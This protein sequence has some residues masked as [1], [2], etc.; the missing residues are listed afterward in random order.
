MIPRE[1]TFHKSAAL[2]QNNRFRQ[3]F[4]S[5]GVVPV[6]SFPVTFSVSAWWGYRWPSVSCR[7]NRT[8]FGIKHQQMPVPAL[9]VPATK[10]R[11]LDEWFLRFR[12]SVRILLSCPLR[13]LP[14]RPGLAPRRTT[15]PVRPF[16]GGMHRCSTDRWLGILAGLYL[17]ILGGPPDGTLA[18]RIDLL[19]SASWRKPWLA[20]H[21]ALDHR[22]PPFGPRLPWHTRPG[23]AR[24]PSGA[25]RPGS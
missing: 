25:R 5:F 11:V 20:I 12:A 3:Y 6:I 16:S 14:A 22:A 19:L 1:A 8:S 9:A 2:Y 4:A 13:G 18:A 21:R 15:R 17:R 24:Q 23:H 10:A 7:R